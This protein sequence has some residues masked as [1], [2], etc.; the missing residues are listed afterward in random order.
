MHRR[1][2][3]ERATAA[4]YA[5][6]SVG[7]KNVASA[8]ERGRAEKSSR[9]LHRNQRLANCRTRS[10]ADV[11]NGDQDVFRKGQKEAV[12]LRRLNQNSPPAGSE[13]CTVPTC[14]LSVEDDRQR[15]RVGAL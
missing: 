7:S 3:I 4:A 15:R 14:Q 12:R 10:S 11:A 2:V 1:H 6:P 8:A 13:F 9:F 5:A